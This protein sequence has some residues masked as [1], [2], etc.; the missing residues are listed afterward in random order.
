MPQVLDIKESQIKSGDSPVTEA[1]EGGNATKKQRMNKAAAGGNKRVSFGIQQTAT[2]EKGTEFRTTPSPEGDAATAAPRPAPSPL[3]ASADADQASAPETSELQN[4]R[5]SFSDA[6][7]VRGLLDLVH[8]DEQDELEQSGQTMEFT[9]NVPL[10]NGIAA[11]SNDDDEE[12]EVPSFTGDATCSMELTSVMPSIS[13]AF[14]PPS[15]API[16]PDANNGTQHFTEMTGFTLPPADD[17]TANLDMK[18]ALSLKDRQSLYADDT[19]THDLTGL[20]VAATSDSVNS[21]T[22][23]DVSAH[24]THSQPAVEAPTPT[25]TEGFTSR[26]R[27]A[28][29]FTHNDSRFL[30]YL[31]PSLPPSLPTSESQFVFFT[32]F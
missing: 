23:T 21:S 31:S 20:L 10:M 3:V 9:G 7:A 1:T 12:D 8:E 5:L 16:F 17:T 15:A 27:R 26:L 28:G 4:K 13:S 24:V 19:G 2:Y 6:G 18:L 30:L 25:G 14:P 11:C 22:Y 32:T 29:S